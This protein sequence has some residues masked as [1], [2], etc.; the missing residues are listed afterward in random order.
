MFPSTPW[1]Y[2]SA[3]HHRKPYQ[4]LYW[5]PG[6]PWVPKKI[7]A[8]LSFLK[9]TLR[10][11]NHS[12]EQSLTRPILL[13]IWVGESTFQPPRTGWTAT[14]KCFLLNHA[15]VT[16]QGRCWEQSGKK[17][18]QAHGLEGQQQL[19]KPQLQKRQNVMWHEKMSSAA[20]ATISHRLK[21]QHT[22]YHPWYKAVPVCLHPTIYWKVLIKELWFGCCHGRNA[23]IYLA[24]CRCYPKTTLA[25]LNSINQIKI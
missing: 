16:A 15:V 6:R 13:L 1:E 21:W 22:Q 24:S 19:G 8:R 14:A 25:S 5:S 4:R 11:L 9:E 23:N 18:H 3:E 2:C 12:G 10:P 20:Q 7:A 17:S